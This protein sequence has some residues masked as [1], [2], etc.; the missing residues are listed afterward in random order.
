[1]TDNLFARNIGALNAKQQHE[2]EQKRVFIAGC[3]GLGGYC[4]EL[5]ARAG[6]GSFTVCDSDCFEPTNTNR[7][8]LCTS[9]TIGEPKV[10]ACAD[11]IKSINPAAYVNTVNAKLSNDN[12]DELIQ[13]HDIVIDALDSPQG[14]LMLSRGCERCSLTLVSAGVSGWCAQVCVSEPGDCL[15]ELLYD[16][17]PQSGNSVLSFTASAAASWQCSFAIKTLLG[18]QKPERR[19]LMLDF[20]NDTAEY[21]KLKS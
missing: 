18:L 7:Q 3:G 4:A 20:L 12:I 14:K 13:G 1:M 8:L 6:I 21:I 16:D 10:Y 11:R 9:K 2:L 19:V 5:L 17:A 15:L